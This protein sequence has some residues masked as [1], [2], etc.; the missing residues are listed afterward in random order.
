[1]TAGRILVVDDAAFNRQLLV[2][3]LA[4]IGY[5]SLEA[6][7]G[8]AAL[9]L[10]RGPAGSDVDVVL[11]DIVMPVL[12]GFAT[13]EALTPPPWWWSCPWVIARVLIPC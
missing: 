2:R 10:L 13:L 1:M 12:D 7:D 9:D 4:S 11:L 3:L 5:E 8:Q 6:V